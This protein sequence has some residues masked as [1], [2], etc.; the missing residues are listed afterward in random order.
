MSNV[1]AL[2]K[3]SFSLTP[4]SLAEAMEFAGM[5]SKASIVPKD[6]Q[7]NPGNILVAIQ[8]GMEIGLQPLQSM[9]SIA[10]INGRP[11]IWGDAMLALVRSSGLLEAINEDV[12]DS[13][14]VCT[15]KRRGE[16]EV[17]REFSMQDAKQAGLTGKQGPWAQYPKRMLQMRARAFA[18]RDVFPDVLRGVH[19]AEEAQDMSERDMG[20]ADVV[21]EVPP[22]SRTSALKAKLLS[23]Q[24]PAAL[25]VVLAQIAA[26]TGKEGLAKAKD[27][28]G[29]LSEEDRA[30]AAGAYKA[31]VSDLKRAAQVNKETGEVAAPMTYAQVAA[32]IEASK[33][34]DALDIALDMIRLV[35]DADQRDELRRLATA[36]GSSES[37]AAQA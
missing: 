12:T 4:S 2:Q 32:M 24:E 26:S 8:W 25:D 3:P 16:Q 15:I 27:L 9:Q 33:D 28:A 13:K 30:T 17:V 5:M 36:I 31:R 21:G 35:Y 29:K 14:A 7:N 37:L 20:S 19:V 18:L 23:K 6:Y 11:S 1:L 10:V 22:A 34:Q